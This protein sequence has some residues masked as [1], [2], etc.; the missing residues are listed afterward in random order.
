MKAVVPQ[1]KYEGSSMQAV[2][3]IVGLAVAHYVAKLGKT[4]LQSVLIYFA[5]MGLGIFAIW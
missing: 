5:I 2:I 4:Q 1:W 3:F